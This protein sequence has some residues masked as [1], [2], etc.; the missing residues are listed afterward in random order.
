MTHNKR[1]EI[2]HRPKKQVLMD[3][4]LPFVTPYGRYKPSINRIFDK[5]WLSIYDDQKFYGL[6]PNKPFTVFK[7][8]KALKSLLSAKRRQ[9]DTK[10]YLLNLDMGEKEAFKYTKFNHHRIW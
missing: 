8:D 7:D 3:R 1:S 2:L 10:R 9:F 5:R 4:A 6:L